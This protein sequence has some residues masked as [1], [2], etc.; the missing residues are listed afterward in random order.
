MLRLAKFSFM[1][2]VLR[3]RGLLRGG[4]GICRFLLVCLVFL[5]VLGSFLVALFLLLWVG[6]VMCLFEGLFG[7]LIII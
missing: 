5:L 1:I 3:R 2:S 6:L 4:F 7:G